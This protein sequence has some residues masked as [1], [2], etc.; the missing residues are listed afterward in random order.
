[1]EDIQPVFQRNL[2]EP[3][4]VPLHWV[5]PALRPV[6]ASDVTYRNECH[7]FNSPDQVEPWGL[8]A[9]F[10]RNHTML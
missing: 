10:P 4:L 6:P 7:G 1:M 5:I 9:F 8:M 2:V 3:A